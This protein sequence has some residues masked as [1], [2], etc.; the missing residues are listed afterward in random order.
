MIK[1]NKLINRPVNELLYFLVINFLT[2]SIDIL[3]VFGSMSANF[4]FAPMYKRG[5]FVAVHVKTGQMIS[6]FFLFPLVNKPNAK[7]LF[8]NL[9]QY[10]VNFL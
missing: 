10:K 2:W 3:K 1:L 6:S 9:Q 7:H 8:L 5:I 4:I